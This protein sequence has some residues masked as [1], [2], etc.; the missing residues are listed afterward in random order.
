MVENIQ[1]ISLAALRILCSG[2]LEVK[3]V[4]P[5]SLGPRA[6]RV[7]GRA[8]RACCRVSSEG[9]SGSLRLIEEAFF[10]QL[11]SSSSS[12]GRSG[13]WAQAVARGK[14]ELADETELGQRISSG[15]YF[16]YGMSPGI[17][18]PALEVVG[19]CVDI[20]GSRIG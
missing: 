13:D 19:S 5:A 1:Q 4:V 20:P 8:A 2:L 16:G 11:L 18:Q 17:S 12:V 6:A 15:P 9:T 10:A 3:G 7:A 14:D